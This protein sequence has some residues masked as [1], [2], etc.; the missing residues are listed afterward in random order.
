LKS[1]VA[2]DEV[3]NFTG[4]Q[5]VKDIAQYIKPYKWRFVYASIIRFIGDFVWLYPPFGLAAIVNYLSHYQPGQSLWPIWIPLLI[6]L[7]ATIVRNVSLYYAKYLGYGIAERVNIDSMLRATRHLF[8][9]DMAWHERQNSG[10]KVKKIQNAAQGY[11][12]IIRR[13]FTSIVSI[14]VNM[15]AMNIIISRFDIKVVLLM[16]AYLTTYFFFASK[17]LK[18]VGKA[19]IRVS[20]QEEVVNGT[21]FEAINNIRTVKV[22][23]MAKA[24]F[25][26]VT[27]DSSE[28]FSRLKRRIVGYQSTS[29]FLNTWSYFFKML[30]VV[31]IAYGV[32]NKHYEVGFLVMLNA[33]FNDLREAIDELSEAAQEFVTGKLNIGRIKKV[34]NEPVTIDNELGKSELPK[35]WGKIIF[36]NVSFSYSNHQ[37]LKNISF[38]VKRGEKI[39]IVGLSGAGKSTLFKLLLKEREGFG[40]KILFDNLPID[41]I[42]ISDYFKTVSVVLQDTEVFNLSLRDNITITNLD[43]GKNKKLLDKAI[44]TAHITDFVDKLPQGLNTLIG[45][46]GVKL[47]GGERQRLGIARAIFKEP[48]LLLLDEATSHL[49]LESEEKIKESLHE[50]FEETTAIVIAHRLTTIKE[51]DKILVMEQGTIV[52]SGSFDELYDKHGRFYELWEKQRL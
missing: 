11:N 12:D 39:G 7:A 15:I 43:E 4:W 9:L 31:V 6:W 18:N 45:E 26:L 14:A 28:L 40:G 36:K 32:A 37:V 19:A 38:E 16:I 24:L 8:R 27:K 13:W 5:L 22:M 48:Q 35:N 10:N 30:M 47:S 46:K 51:M 23:S 52:E 3:V 1:K 44:E 29:H 49:D 33:Y 42:K 17:L 41:T 21:L 20:A 25:Q 50:F 2:E 34:L